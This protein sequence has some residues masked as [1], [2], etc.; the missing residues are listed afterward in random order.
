[1]TFPPNAMTF[2]PSDRPPATTPPGRRAG[3]N[4]EAAP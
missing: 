4:P 1:M 3:R 2:P